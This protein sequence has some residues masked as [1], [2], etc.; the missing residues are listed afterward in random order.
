MKMNFYSITLKFM[1][2]TFFITVIGLLFID[3]Q[4]EINQGGS[5]LP[6]EITPD[7]TMISPGAIDEASGIADSKKNQGYLWVQQDSGN[8]PELYLLSYNGIVIKRIYIKGA[9]NRDWEDI[10][11]GTGPV[12]GNDY[13]YIAETGDNTA[14]FSE[15]FIYRMM[16]PSLTE[17]TI[18]TWDKIS[19]HYPD[20]SHDVEAIISDPATNDIL[21]ITKKDSLSKIFRLPYP[22]NTSTVNL[23]IEEGAMKITGACSAAISPDGKEILVKNYTNIYYW[24]RKDGESI[25]SALKR[26]PLTL[27]YVLEPQ[28]EAVCFKNDNSGFYTLS[29]K[30]F[31]AS[32]VTLNFYKRK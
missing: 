9:F 32:F 23:A 13:L 1:K 6:F 12:A 30:P 5:S 27:G 7:T 25:T 4:K 26:M 21:L 20:N 11:T 31:Y 3:C 29:E 17:D 24:K 8:P 15:Y 22:Q 28:G 19:F 18:Y 16:E 10:T 2:S 14:T